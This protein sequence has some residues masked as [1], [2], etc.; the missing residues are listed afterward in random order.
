MCV[1]TRTLFL[2]WVAAA[3]HLGPALRDHGSRPNPFR[4]PLNPRRARLGRDGR[5][6]DAWGQAARA[7]SRDINS[8]ALGQVDNSDTDAARMHNRS[9]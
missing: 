5:D 1:E 9:S 6:P 4:L 3:T 7:T 8:G 2:S